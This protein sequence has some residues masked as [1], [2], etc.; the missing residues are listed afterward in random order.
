MDFNDISLCGA[1][2]IRPLRPRFLQRLGRIVDSFKSNPHRSQTFDAQDGPNQAR[3]EG[4]K[5]NIEVGAARHEAAREAE[6]ERGA[7]L[8]AIP[9]RSR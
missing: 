4:C 9:R 2:A 3:S 5:M 6:R 8:A 7:G 1:N